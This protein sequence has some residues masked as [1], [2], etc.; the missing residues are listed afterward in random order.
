M[1]ATSWNWNTCVVPPSDEAKAKDSLFL[2]FKINISVLV[3]GDLLF[4]L[5]LTAKELSLGKYE[6]NFISSGLI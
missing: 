1:S 5:I 3:K 4:V 6:F 2:E